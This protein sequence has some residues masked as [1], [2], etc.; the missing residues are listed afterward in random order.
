MYKVI[1]N[2]YE[3]YCQIDEESDFFDELT[4][5]FPIQGK[6]EEEVD[7][8][9]YDRLNNLAWNHFGLFS[10]QTEIEHKIGY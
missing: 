7:D 8:M 3:N 2:W 6:S 4:N 5:L 1:V 9:I 10:Q